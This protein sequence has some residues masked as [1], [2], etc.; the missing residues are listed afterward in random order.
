VTRPRSLWDHV[1]DWAWGAYG[2]VLVSIVVTSPKRRQRNEERAK[3]LMKKHREHL[4]RL[5]GEER[6]REFFGE[7]EQ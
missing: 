4:C 1:C 7:G 5:H 3:E 2:L 6:V